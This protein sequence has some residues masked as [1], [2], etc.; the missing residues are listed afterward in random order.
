MT[1]NSTT[2][3]LSL[4]GSPQVSGTCT[5]LLAHTTNGRIWV[6]SAPHS[7]LRLTYKLDHLC[8]F[9]AVPR[10]TSSAGCRQPQNDMILVDDSNAQSDLLERR[11]ARNLDHR[12]PLVAL[13]HCTTR[14]SSEPA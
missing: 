5:L 12:R 4:I 13:R 1:R 7:L 8:D 3:L 2:A 14:R 6:R 9:Y 10:I 11:V